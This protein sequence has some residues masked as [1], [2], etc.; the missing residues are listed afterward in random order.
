MLANLTRI[1]TDAKM[2]WQ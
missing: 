2:L 1:A